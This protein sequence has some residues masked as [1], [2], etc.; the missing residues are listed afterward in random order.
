MKAIYI[1]SFLILSSLFSVAQTIPD[2]QA[3]LIVE[4]PWNGN[5]DT[6][7]IGLDY[8]A[9]DGYDA[10]FDVIDT[11]FQYPLAMRSRITELETDSGFCAANMKVNIK[12]FAPVVTWDIYIKADTFQPAPDHELPIDSIALFKWDTAQFNYED[13]QYFL[14]YALIY[15][16]TGYIH[17]IDLNSYCLATNTF[18]CEGTSGG[19]HTETELYYIYGIWPY[20]YFFGGCATEEYIYK[21]TVKIVFTDLLL[22]TDFSTNIFTVFNNI[23]ASA[24]QINFKDEGEKTLQV[25]NIQG[26]QMMATNNVYELYYKLDYASLP[27]GLYFL[28]YHSPDNETLVYTFIKP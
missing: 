5:T 24:L 19:A 20:E 12:A 14:E 21:L 1:H 2:W 23:N 8:D 18:L 26:K 3:H 9:T 13:E 28:L 11:N 6:I 22:V 16:T 10:A 27:T 15:S 25:Y 4:Q 7:I 17:G